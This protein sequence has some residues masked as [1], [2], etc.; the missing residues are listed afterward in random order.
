MDAQSLV[1][2]NKKEVL[3]EIVHHFCMQI[4]NPLAILTQ[5]TARSFLATSTPKQRYVF[6]LEGTG[7][8]QLDLIYDNIGNVK[9]RIQAILERKSQTLPELA[10]QVEFLQIKIEEHE[11]MKELEDQ[12]VS[13]RE[14]LIWQAVEKE[15]SVLKGLQNECKKNSS[16]IQSAQT[17]IASKEEECKDYDTKKTLIEQRIGESNHDIP[18]LLNRQEEFRNEIQTLSRQMV[19]LQSEE[20]EIQRNLNENRATAKE[21]EMKISKETERLA[22]DHA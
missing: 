11:R 1:V 5:D 14:E 17:K 22:M 7:L 9:E 12:L 20:K 18:P 21:F 16:K 19:D 13:F 4:E 3:A 2:S 6:F 10:K 8:R 15:E